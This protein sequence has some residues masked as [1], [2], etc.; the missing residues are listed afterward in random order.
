MKIINFEYYNEIHVRILKKVKR[1]R[2]IKMLSQLIYAKRCVDECDMIAKYFL[3]L[4]KLQFNLLRMFSS[5][6]K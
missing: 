5:K 3:I 1:N 2:S 4:T 6:K